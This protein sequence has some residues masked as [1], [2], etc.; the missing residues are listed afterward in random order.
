MDYKRVNEFGTTGEMHVGPVDGENA[1]IEGAKTE[2]AITNGK[3][4]A[5][6]PQ[7]PEVAPKSAADKKVD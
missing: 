7:A 4:D 1:E 5:D 3:S 2:G 6:T